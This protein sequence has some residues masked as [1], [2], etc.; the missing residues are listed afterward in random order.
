MGNRIAKPLPFLQ[1]ADLSFRTPMEHLWAES[2]AEETVGNRIARPPPF[3]L[4]AD[5]DCGQQVWRQH[6]EGCG[7]GRP[8]GRG[9]E[10]WPPTQGSPGQPAVFP[11]AVILPTGDRAT[12]EQRRGWLS[13]KNGTE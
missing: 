13:W 8:C 3:L 12:W 6:S 2:D 4:G 1:R 9:D 7:A 10:A 11:P 5:L